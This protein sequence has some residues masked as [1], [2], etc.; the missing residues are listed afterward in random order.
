[1]KAYLVKNE[2]EWISILGKLYKSGYRWSNK[3][4]ADNNSKS[5]DE[6]YRLNLMS[7]ERYP[8]VILSGDDIKN[9]KDLHYCSIDYIKRNYPNEYI[10]MMR[11]AKIKKIEYENR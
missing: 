10:K 3:N 8:I 6:W 4:P 11:R 9:D 5:F 1:M 7:N 2:H